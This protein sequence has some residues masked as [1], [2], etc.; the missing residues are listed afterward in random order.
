MAQGNHR[1][2]TYTISPDRAFFSLDS[3]ME[4][5]PTAIRT[6]LRKNPNPA[7][8]TINVKYN[9]THSEAVAIR[10]FMKAVG[11]IQKK[12]FVRFM[13]DILWAADSDNAG[14]FYTIDGNTR[15]VSDIVWDIE[16]TQNHLI[17]LTVS[18]KKR[19]SNMKFINDLHKKVLDILVNLNEEGLP[20]DM[21]EVADRV[22]TD[23]FADKDI[24]ELDSNLSVI[25]LADRTND[26]VRMMPHIVYGM[27]ST[28]TRAKFRKSFRE[29]VEAYGLYPEWLDSEGI[30]IGN[31]IVTLHGTITS[32][33]EDREGREKALR[34]IYEH[35][36]LLLSYVC[37]YIN[38]PSVV[39]G[40]DVIIIDVTGDPCDGAEIY[41]S[42]IN[43]LPSKSETN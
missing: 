11:R 14:S 40:N 4:K 31:V 8:I 42:Q 16:V 23:L 1:V 9:G 10:R 38:D 15:D 19:T 29:I 36:E 5:C 20:E 24:R 18:K 6:N 35:T 33:F 21:F 30:S 17:R 34:E 2:T 26:N 3:L 27:S 37:E 41:L 7:I 25:I 28:D 43:L 13:T 39:S 12:Y 32:I 22:G